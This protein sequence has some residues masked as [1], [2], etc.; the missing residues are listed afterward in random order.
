MIVKF[1]LWP[2]KLEAPA[3]HSRTCQLAGI[4]LLEATCWLRRESSHT[5]VRRV[6]GVSR[7]HVLAY[8]KRIAMLTNVLIRLFLTTTTYSVLRTELPLP[9]IEIGRYG[10]AVTTNKLSHLLQLVYELVG[11]DT[12]VKN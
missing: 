9:I 5:K 11:E 8:L 6:D 12:S 1:R 7:R 4:V 3:F 2:L 10:D